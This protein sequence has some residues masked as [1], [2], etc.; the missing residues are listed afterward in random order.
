M[1]M[2][3]H[4]YR[5]SKNIQE[6]WVR[7]N[8]KARKKKSVHICI[9]MCICNIKGAEF[10]IFI[11]VKKTPYSNSNSLKSNYALNSSWSI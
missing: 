1:H 8:V 2:I 9:Y 3:I 7:E 11:N 10:S 5:E 4:F 6:E